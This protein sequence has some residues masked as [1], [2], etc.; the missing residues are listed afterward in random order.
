MQCYGILYD[1]I[2]IVLVIVRFNYFINIYFGNQIIINEIKNELVYRGNNWLGE[3][4]IR[5]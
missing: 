1:E 4:K 5:I 2:E 3:L